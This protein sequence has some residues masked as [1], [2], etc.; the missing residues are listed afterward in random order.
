MRRILLLKSVFYHSVIFL[1]FDIKIDLTN[2]SLYN[3]PMEIKFMTPTEVWESFNPVKEPLETYVEKCQLKNDCLETEMF[4]TAETVADGKVR[5][6]CKMIHDQHLNEK[7]PAVLFLA[8][9][10]ENTAFDEIE[11]LFVKNGYVVFILDYAGFVTS[12][13]TR[14]SFPESLKFAS[15]ENAKNN[16]GYMGESARVTPWFVW[17]KIARR[18][19]TLIGEQTLVDNEKINLVGY[20]HGAQLAW[21]VAGI[22]GRVHAAMPVMGCGYNNYGKKDTSLSESEEER[23]WVSGICPETYAHFI[24]CP[25]A[26]AT[27]TNNDFACID[28]ANEIMAGISSSSKILCI[29]PR[30]NKQLSKDCFLGLLKWANSAF[31]SDAEKLP[32]PTIAFTVDG[33]KLTLTVDTNSDCDCIETFISY[34]NAP[35]PIRDWFSL[36]ESKTDGFKHVYDVV[37]FDNNEKLS[38][39]AN[40]TFNGV[41]VSTLITSISRDKFDGVKQAPAV[42]ESNR[43]VYTNKKG[44]A[45][46]APRT[47]SVIVDEDD[48]KLKKGPFGI[49]GVSVDSGYLTTN[50]LMKSDFAK[51]K[52]SILKIDFYSPSQRDIRI[53]LTS[54]YTGASYVAK[55]SLKGGERWQKVLLTPSDFKSEDGKPLGLFADTQITVFK[56]VAGVILNNI[57]WI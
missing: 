55:C 37:P 2:Y 18:A 25:I 23:A 42:I 14:T 47:F 28:K 54:I 13:E 38:A 30:T 20:I 17:S 8:N 31:K 35:A 53:Q 26:Y 11:K 7:R 51:D 3:L 46:F 29:S 6:Y 57:I 40:V 56:N 41:V 39:F 5:A 16:L 49:K 24:S 12:R 50:N 34:D 4:F 19:I 44:I 22:D 36:V 9:L 27:S 43:I 1:S 21:I 52:A 45:S 33:D 10:S 15:Y 48:L 32:L